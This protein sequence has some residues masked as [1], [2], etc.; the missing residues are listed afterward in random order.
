MKKLVLLGFAFAVTLTARAQKYVAFTMDDLPFVGNYDSASIYSEGILQAFDKF[1]IKA[2]GFV[3]DKFVLDQK[4]KGTKV[5]QAW[6]EKGHELGNHTFSHM[7]LTESPLEDY[8]EDIKAGQQ[9]S[10]EL[11]KKYNGQEMRYFRHPYLQTGNDSLKRY[12]LEAALQGMSLQAVPVTLDGSDWYFN[13]AYV[14][15]N[16]KEEIAKA[17]INYTLDNVAYLEKLTAEIHEGSAAHIF[18]VHANPLNAKYL[19]TILQALKD[20]GY[21]FISV[22]KA[23]SH[24]IYQKPDTVIVP[25]G[26]SWLHRWRISAKQKT[27]LKEPE[28]P[29][30]VKEAY[31]K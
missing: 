11:Q 19:S 8:I 30:F 17:Y 2:V 22:D 5:L 1:G 24:P 26:F 7:S 4:D 20:R 10:A 9:Y 31:E 23:L 29:R 13:Q 14:K 12:G 27:S 18:L 6:L 15:S 28:I 3:N 21:Q 25:G 16:R